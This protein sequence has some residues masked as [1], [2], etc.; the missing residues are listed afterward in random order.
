MLDK[1]IRLKNI[2][3]FH[4][5][6]CAR[7]TIGDF[8]LVF[9]ENGAGKTTLAGVMRS[10]AEDE[11]GFV[12]ERA[13]VG[14]GSDPRVKLLTRANDAL[15][16][17]SGSWTGSTTDVS[18]NVFDSHFINE[19]I[20]SGHTLSHDHKKRLHRFVI[21]ERGHSLSEK[22]SR[23]D[24]LSRKLQQHLRSIEDRIRDIR[25]SDGNIEE[26]VQLPKVNDVDEKIEETKK[27]L[28][29]QERASELRV[30]DDLDLPALPNV[31]IGEVRDLLSRSLD[32]VSDTAESVVVG[33]ISDCMDDNGESWVQQGL[34]YAERE[35]C[36]FCGRD[37]T[38]VDL[39]T[40]YRDYFSAEYEALKANVDNEK[41]K[42][43][44]SILIKNGWHQV[45]GI[46][47]NN[48]NRFRLW[49]DYID[50]HHAI[51]ETLKED[52]ETAWTVLR[53]TLA[54][55]LDQK[56]SAPLEPIEMNDQALEAWEDYQGV[57][58]R[59]SSYRE[60]VTEVNKKIA[61]FKKSLEVGSSADLRESLA[62]LQDSKNRHS[63]LGSSLARR[64]KIN[65][66]RKQ[67]ILDEKEKAKE[68]LA[69]YQSYTLEA[70]QT[71]I[72]S[73]L[74]QA[75]AAFKIREAEVGYQGGTAN[76]R[77]SL[78]INER[79]IGIGNAVTEV[80]KP[81]FRNLLSEGD[82]TTLAFAFFYARMEEADDLS[83]RMIVI[84][85]P[86]SSLD[87]HRRNATRDAIIRL[88]ERA[89]Q[90]IVFS[91]NPRFLSSLLDKRKDQ[92]GDSE[93]FHIRK[94]GDKTSEFDGWD[95]DA[96]NRKIQSRYYRQFN[97]LVAYASNRE[98]EPEVVSRCIRH[99]IEGN[100]RRRFPD[101]YK[102]SDGSVGAFIGMVDNAD[103]D[104]PLS[105]LQG[106]P[107][108]EE[109]RAIAASDYCHDPHHDDAPF[110]PPVEN[111]TELAAW[112]K[113]TIQFARGLPPQN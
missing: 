15:H 43:S 113:R 61:D 91:H 50:S 88:A 24:T 62:H 52:V 2:G 69:E 70:C 8:N 65:R 31:P 13:T 40:A 18:V 103:T 109:L 54:N 6:E 11:A 68:D 83:D 73:F 35:E 112:V 36:P 46:L 87:E 63:E 9:A 80:G 49:D 33:H 64:L 78:E 100:L 1:L 4:H 3:R 57:D 92:G 14:S 16:F 55:L 59:L 95:E 45:T 105:D 90:T 22:I 44:T 17:K 37:L 72:N 77:F 26:F 53:T 99:V 30:Q 38:G 74:R 96:L 71:R 108:L 107:Y 39:I 21:G 41:R 32:H 93:L 29:A 67:L 86:I 75:G 47:D 10:L 66:K 101:R 25:I 12:S 89:G 23:I 106:T 5:C 20:Y 56:R 19:N 110:I 102:K 111:E 51:P 58:Q 84:D 98:G 7:L 79:Q 76:A 42:L 82:K 104:N 81:S 60:V 85:D 97:K 48:E 34:E 28:Q 94:T 27:H